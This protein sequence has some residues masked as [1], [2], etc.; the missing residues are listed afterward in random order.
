MVE[1]LARLVIEND[2]IAQAAVALGGVARVPLRLSDVARHLVGHPAKKSTLRR[3]AAL[4]RKGAS[5]L[6]MTQ[7]KVDLVETSVYDALAQALCCAQDAPHP[8]RHPSPGAIP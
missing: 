1:V 2:I 7:Y 8:E 4:A 3:A 5:P 6:P